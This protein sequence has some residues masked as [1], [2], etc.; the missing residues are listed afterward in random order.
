VAASHRPAPV[1]DF[2]IPVRGH[3]GILDDE[4]QKLEY[5]STLC[6]EHCV[7]V[8]ALIEERE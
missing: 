6:A 3:D 5:K 2:S 8:W 7:E 1:P 4:Q